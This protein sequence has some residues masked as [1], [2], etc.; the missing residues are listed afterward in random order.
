[1]SWGEKIHTEGFQKTVKE[2]T[3][4]SGKTRHSRV[5]FSSHSEDKG[6]LAQ[7]LSSPSTSPSPRDGVAAP[8]PV[9]WDQGQCGTALCRLAWGRMQD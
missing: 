6:S 5:T 7:G 4:F 9:R 3:K 8:M 1:M 2:K